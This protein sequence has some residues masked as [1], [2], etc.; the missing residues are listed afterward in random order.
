MTPTAESTHEPRL[1][2]L[3]EHHIAPVLRLYRR[4]IL[5]TWLERGRDHDFGRIEGNIRARL[6]QPDRWM[7]VVPMPGSAEL[8]GYLAWE[9]HPDHTSTHTIAHLRMILVHPDW[10]GSGLG[11]RLLRWFE[12][13]AK[14]KGCSKAL[15]DVVAG[16]PARGFY[17]RQG[18]RH[19]GEAAVGARRVQAAQTL[20]AE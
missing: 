2:P 16:S 17:D 8:A 14:A 19:S 20:R 15:F 5:P 4:A 7:L 6:G 1:V 3:A 13:A 9:K 10:Q 12:D 11:A 18:Y